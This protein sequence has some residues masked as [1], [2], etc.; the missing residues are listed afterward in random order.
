MTYNIKGIFRILFFSV[1]IFLSG[2]NK[3]PDY[4][5]SEKD[6]VS[7]MVD[8]QIAEAYSDQESG[9][10]NLNEK[11]SELSNSVLKQHGIT[12]E[13]LD[14][15]LAWYGR[16]LDEYKDLYQ[17]V[18]KELRSRRAVLLGNEEDKEENIASNSLWPY[19][20]NGVISELG[21]SD[22]WI[23]SI[24][25][26]ELQKG[27]MLEWNMHVKGTNAITG[28][29]GVEYNDGTSEAVHTVF[30]ARQ[31]LELRLQTDTAKTVE[32]IYGSMR[33]KS[34]ARLPLYADSIY[35]RR[36]PFDSLE[37]RKYRNQKKYGKPAKIVPEPA[38]KKDSTLKVDSLT[39]KPL[40]V[41]DDNLYRDENGAPR[42]NP[43]APLKKLRFNTGNP[44]DPKI[45]KP[46]SRLKRR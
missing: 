14:T 9:G 27:D 12:R 7:L 31:N 17:K 16:N 32:R 8:M 10:P 3:R 13:Q 2:C 28:V 1:L 26:P 40:E 20:R 43:D 46:E 22:S 44:N 41:I 5:I 24:D 42:P 39:V 15:T 11:K 6:M 35:V 33:L 25:Q 45:Q 38:E 21:N 4:V 19:S 36:L 34:D 37:F 18:D 30:T 29:L 23:L